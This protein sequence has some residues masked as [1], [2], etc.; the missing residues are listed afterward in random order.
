MTASQPPS[1]PQPVSQPSVFPPQAAP[2]GPPP[3]PPVGQTTPAHRLT[4]FRTWWATLAEWRNW[5]LPVKVAAVLAVPAV[6]AIVLGAVQIHGD[7]SSANSYSR[8]QRVVAL[9]TTLMPLVTDLQTERWMAAQKLGTRTLINV[10]AYYQLNGRVQQDAADV[11]SLGNGLLDP[12]TAAGIRYQ[13]LV[14]QLAGMAALHQQALDAKLDVD[15]VLSNYGGLISAV[16]DLDQALSTQLGDPTLTGAATAMTD[17]EVGQEQIRQQQAVVAVAISRGELLSPE[18]TTVRS[19]DVVLSN[20]IE[21]FTVVAT[22]AELARYQQ[23]AIIDDVNNREQL[24]QAVLAN[25]QTLLEVGTTGQNGKSLGITA[26]TWITASNATAGRL[27]GVQDQLARELR[28]TSAT[29]QNGASDA[30]GI[31]SVVLFAILLLAVGVGV[32]VGRHLLRSL[33]ILRRTALEVAEHQLPDVVASIDSG[34]LTGLEIEPVPVH[35][36]EELG[37]LARAF[38]AVHGQAVRSAVGQATL[39]SNLRNIFINLSRRSQGLVERQL[40]LMEKLERNEEDPQ[41]L[42]NLFRLDHLATRMRRNNENLMVLSGDDP[43]RRS[44]HPLPL[45][46][47]LRAAVSEIEQYQRVVVR[48]TPSMDVLGYASGDLVRLVAELLDNAT[49][50]SPP[51]TQVRI[52]GQTFPDG[53]VRIEIRDEGIGMA[54]AELA[55]AN[56]RLNAADSADVPVSRQM[57]LYVVGR[58]AKRHSIAVSLEVPPEGGLLAVVH[59]PA[60]LVKPGSGPVRP[61]DGVVAGPQANGVVAGPQANGRAVNGHTNGNGAAHPLPTFGTSGPPSRPDLTPAPATEFEWGTFAGTTIGD[62]NLNPTGFTWFITKGAPAPTQP[63]GTPPT[64]A[65]RHTNGGDGD[66]A[67]QPLS[68]TDVGLPRRVP[69]SHVVPSLVQQ[70]GQ[71]GQ[72]GQIGQPGQTGRHGGPVRQRADAHARGPAAAQAQRNPARA[73]GFL[74]DY[75]AGLRQGQP[76]PADTPNSGSPGGLPGT[77]QGEAQ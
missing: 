11:T 3:R 67:Q 47:V 59:V 29:L 9:R 13:G 18:L 31:E 40:R 60:E 53:S 6:A 21:D 12:T 8:I 50:F 71:S 7:V 37:Q 61:A 19:S 34:N 14:G 43:A 5:R 23:P 16:L 4:G 35:T 2:A 38:D 73:R 25:G 24:A 56:G 54:E 51:K 77:G 45:A 48:S 63:A 28:D 22:P 46:D 52:G 10:P 66:V 75:Q 55:D 42:A 69:R 41:Q 30:A 36:H 74:D 20:R 1:Q 76:E 27:G 65:P 57:G 33:G 58:L 68:Y 49:S 70:H 26:P 39:R 15:T 44:G 32:V 62:L 64:S 17:L 72:T